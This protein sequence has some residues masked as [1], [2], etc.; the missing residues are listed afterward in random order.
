MGRTT[1]LH[2]KLCAQRERELDS[3]ESLMRAKIGQRY[4]ILSV[5]RVESR[6]VNPSVTMRLRHSESGK[7]RSVSA[8]SVNG[9]T[10]WLWYD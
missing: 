7:A 10:R 1:D 3:I 4:R 6:S 9:K 8:W 5:D 2:A